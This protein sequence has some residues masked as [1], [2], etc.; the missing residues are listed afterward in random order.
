[1]LTT[2]RLPSDL[3]GEAYETLKEKLFYASEAIQAV[4]LVGDGLLRLE[5]VDKPG[6]TSVEDKIDKTIQRFV[7]RGNPPPQ[8]IMHMEPG[9]KTEPDGEVTEK[10]LRSG[11]IIKLGEGQFALTGIALELLDYFDR[12]IRN[13]GESFGA[14]EYRYPTIIPIRAMQRIN[15]LA[16]R[17]EC[18]NFV[19]HLREDVD[20]IDEFSAE[21]RTAP[22]EIKLGARVETDCINAVAVCI[23]TH[24]HL[25]D[26]DLG[27]AK[28]IVGAVGKCMRYETRNTD[29]LRRLRDFTMR[30]IVCV[31]S[32][33]EVLAFRQQL[34]SSMKDCLI[35]WGLSSF[36]A[37]ASDTFFTAEFTSLSDF[38]KTFGLKYEVRAHLSAPGDSLA[39]CSL[40]Y[41]Q[42]FM[43]KGFGIE[44]QGHPA[45]SVCAGYGLERC[46]YAFL[47]QHGLKRSNWPDAVAR[48]VAGRSQRD[49]R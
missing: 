49:E 21:A 29:S 42:D 35:E 8:R 28:K 34:L 1:M 6:A 30:E 15:Y 4:E 46:V 2:R 47:T 38:Q 32:K 10:L 24:H 27:A 26:S 16:S 11:A 18:L 19:S 43:G 48:R 5:L 44:A 33:D 13:L 7:A 3:S 37:T 25:Q 39:I 23:H 17:P 40:N 31:G 45:H 12:D 22:P 9:T 20:V 36:I 14:Q 41:H